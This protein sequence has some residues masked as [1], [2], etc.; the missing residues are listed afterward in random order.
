MLT[1]DTADQLAIQ[2]LPTFRHARNGLQLNHEGMENGVTLSLL[3]IRLLQKTLKS[4][5]NPRAS[6]DNVRVRDTT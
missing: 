3:A 5:R 2:E 6:I 1:R 4:I